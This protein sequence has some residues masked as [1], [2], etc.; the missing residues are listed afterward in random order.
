MTQEGRESE[1]EGQRKRARGDK[2]GAN[3]KK[4]VKRMKEK[5]N[6]KETDG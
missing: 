4:G 1:K 5:T 6:G 2:R 3:G